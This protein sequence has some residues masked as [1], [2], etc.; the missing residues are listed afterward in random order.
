MLY[1]NITCI[2]FFLIPITGLLI[3]VMVISPEISKYTGLDMALLFGLALIAGN[4]TI[5][6]GLITAENTTELVFFGIWSLVSG[7]T[8]YLLQRDWRRRHELQ[9]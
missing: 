3:Q 4:Y 5:V 7:V 2:L 1:F 9:Y 6:T 8:L